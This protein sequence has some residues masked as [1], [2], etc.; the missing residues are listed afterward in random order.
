M[1]YRQGYCHKLLAVFL[2]LHLDRKMGCFYKIENDL[3]RTINYFKPLNHSQK[4]DTISFS[5]VYNMIMEHF[6]Q[7]F[8]VLLEC[9]FR[10]S[11]FGHLLLFF[12][13]KYKLPLMFLAFKPT[14]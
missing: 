2:G 9:D 4:E 6:V 3:E 11:F 8:L 7:L 10:C 12:T 5:L 13:S 1:S 14:P